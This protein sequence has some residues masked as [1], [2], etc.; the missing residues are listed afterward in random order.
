MR[1]ASGVGCW[2]RLCGRFAKHS[3]VLALAVYAG[4]HGQRGWAQAS[5]GDA[6]SRLAAVNNLYQGKTPFHLKVAFQLYDVDGKP[7]EAGTAEEWWA[8]PKSWRISI[9]SPS[10]HGDA[11]LPSDA[12][13]AMVRELYLV[14]RLLVYEVRPA[15]YRGISKPG[16]SIKE[17]PKQI[18]K[19]TLNC[20]NLLPPKA[21]E[22]LPSSEKLCTETG[23]DALRYAE[24]GTE[25][26][27]RNSIG[28]FHDIYVAQD[29]ELR[30][31]GAKVIT[32]KIV[33]LQSI[34]PANATAELTPA[35]SAGGAEVP[36][37]NPLRFVTSD[38]FVGKLISVGPSEYPLVAK[39]S[40][41]SGRVVLLCSIGKDGRVSGVVPLASTDVVF[42]DPAVSEVSR[43][44]YSPYLQDGRPM[45]VE[46]FVTL[47]FGY[48]DVR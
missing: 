42:A 15:P 23:S 31:I 9:E 12:P 14:K 29:L 1:L 46:T 26:S 3:L 37:P 11:T 27:I 5:D 24:V 4:L 45:T 6:W 40:H 21:K 41:K 47:T 33:G 36:V 17:E 10:L 18:G 20:E 16:E 7:G 43:W 2:L 28:K 30:V 35:L 38:A 39:I 22:V 48:F 34:D 13:P 32:G 19:T 25:T 44:K 8:S